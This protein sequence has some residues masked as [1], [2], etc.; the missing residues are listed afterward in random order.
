M[1]N[2]P[3]LV[4]HGFEGHRDM[5]WFPWIREEMAKCDTVII[6]PNLPDSG[7][8]DIAAHM[9][10]L[11]EYRDMLGGSP[12]V[13]GHSLGAATALRWI[14][15][16]RLHPVRLVLIAPVAPD[17]ASLS[18]YAFP[19]EFYAYRDT[20]LD[21]KYLS[22]AVDEVV[23]F[24]SHDDPYIDYEPTLEYYRTL[25]GRRL[26]LREYPSAGHFNAPAGYREFPDLLPYLLPS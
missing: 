17:V 12:V 11:D 7:K 18:D 26:T 10:A 2:N 22:E 3:V 13:I 21:E 8:P 1:A 19:V 9:H 20:P 15:H 4:L 25:F 16:A 24:L 6:C 14:S 23:L 5:N